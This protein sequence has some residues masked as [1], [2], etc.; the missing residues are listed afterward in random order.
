MSVKSHHQNPLEVTFELVL[1]VLIAGR[2]NCFNFIL[3]ISYSPLPFLFTFSR[4][5]VYIYLYL[6]T[7]HTCILLSP[8]NYFCGYS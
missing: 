7:L 2:I 1:F 4:M 6:L 3:M 5:Y 8:Y